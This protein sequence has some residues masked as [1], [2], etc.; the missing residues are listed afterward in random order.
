MA[1]G[2]PKRHY[3]GYYKP[4]SEPENLESQLERRSSRDLILQIVGIR[5]QSS[6]SGGIIRDNGYP[7]KKRHPKIPKLAISLGAFVAEV[8]DPHSVPYCLASVFYLFF[9]QAGAGR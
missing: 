2:T 9:F 5:P 3:A 4:H 1:I 7:D 6:A 8:L